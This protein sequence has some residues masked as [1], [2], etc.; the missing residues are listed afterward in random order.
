MSQKIVN[1]NY[2]RNK[3]Y[4]TSLKRKLHDANREAMELI[5]CPFIEDSD[6]DSV[7]NVFMQINFC[8]ELLK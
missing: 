7:R 5:D 1:K 2:I 8:L 4:L 3:S 6:L